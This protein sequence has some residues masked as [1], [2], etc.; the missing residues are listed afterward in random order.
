MSN[1]M[2]RLQ[3]PYLIV[4]KIF[5]EKFNKPNHNKI[6]LCIL[7]LYNEA[8]CQDSDLGMLIQ[9]S[10]PWALEWEFPT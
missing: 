3:N 9:T 5:P 7:N 4:N 10:F 2:K 8:L 1:S 6:K